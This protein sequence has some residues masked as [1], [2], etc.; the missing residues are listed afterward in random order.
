LYDRDPDDRASGPLRGAGARC[1]L[2]PLLAAAKQAVLIGAATLSA[3][4]AVAGNNAWTGWMGELVPPRIRGRYFGRRGAFCALGAAAGGLGAGLALDWGGAA[5]S[6][7]L[8]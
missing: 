7:R 4:L 8:A 6:V 5:D 2:A 1:A 3:G